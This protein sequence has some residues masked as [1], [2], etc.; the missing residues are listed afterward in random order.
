MALCCLFWFHPLLWLL[1]RRL[2]AEREEACDER[3]LELLGRA[4]AYAQGL[5]KAVRFGIGWRLA[6]VSSAH[7]SNFGRRIERILAS[8]VGRRS[9]LAERGFLGAS[10]ALL[11]AFSL[12]AGAGVPAAA[13]R[14]EL[15]ASS[16]AA[17]RPAAE[18]D[19]CRLERLKVERYRPEAVS[20]EGV[21][22]P[23]LP[24]CDGSDKKAASPASAVAR[25]P[26]RPPAGAATPPPPAPAPE[27]AD[28][29]PD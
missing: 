24:R 5:L 8:P 25:A 11:V 9:S 17:S 23:A 7:A 15:A 29:H 13:D 3:V 16:A 20:D 4:E 14:C 26:H 6:G 19:R 21:P 10:V 22:A 1:D 28:L 2:L 27:A 18:S 12:A